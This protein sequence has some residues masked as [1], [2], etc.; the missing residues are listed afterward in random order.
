MPGYLERLFTFAKATDRPPLENFTTEALAGAIREDPSPFLNA[1]ARLKKLSPF[2][3]PVEVEEVE[4]QVTV[5]GGGIVD[6]VVTLNSGGERRVLWVEIK[7]HAGLHGEQLEIYVQA[8]KSYPASKVEVLMLCKH[9]LIDTVPTLRW[10]ELLQPIDG[11]SHPRWRDLRDFLEGH[12]VADRHDEAI[13]AAELEIA[14][15]AHALLGKVARFTQEFVSSLPPKW[16]ALGFPTNEHKLRK[17]VGQQFRD[18]GRFVASTSASP[19]ICVG[20]V[21]D[22]GAEL[23]LWVEFKPADRDGFRRYCE[24]AKRAKLDEQQWVIRDSRWPN[25]SRSTPLTGDLTH[26]TIGQWLRA[27]LD[28]LDKAGIIDELIGAG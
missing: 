9:Q 14:P 16:S 2:R 8:A 6:L 19:Y 22:S 10:N 27:R 28:E 21:F 4:T 15:R 12:G 26:A 20:A 13:T 5:A 3:Y 18:H 7:A 24:L 11:G 23:S 1:V 25:I 17:M